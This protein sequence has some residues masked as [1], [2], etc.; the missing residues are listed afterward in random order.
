MSGGEAEG[1][2]YCSLCLMRR[3]ASKNMDNS[4]TIEVLYFLLFLNNRCKPL[5]QA[6]GI[7]K[8]YGRSQVLTDI[9]FTFPVGLTLLTGPSG[10]GKST[11]LRLL[12]TAEEP[13]EGMLHWKTRPLSADRRAFR[14]VLGYA[15]QMVDLPDDL[16]AREF[17]LYISALKELD[18]ASADEQ[19]ASIADAIGLYADINNR[20]STFS[21]GMR[22]RLIFAQ[23]LLGKPEILV[24]DEPTAELDQQTASKVMRLI[25]ECTRESVVIMTTHN[26]DKM[27][28]CAERVLKIEAGKQTEP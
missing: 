19:F 2:L 9:R 14:R 20:L 24:L 18:H 28:C 5:L 7:C 12:A 8:R 4:Y 23:A 27:A 13:S 17:V 21:G 16:T 6:T 15:P 25:A 26:A 11:L 22:R 3:S 10:S 1:R